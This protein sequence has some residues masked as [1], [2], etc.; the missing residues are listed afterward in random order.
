MILKIFHA[1]FKKGKVIKT[2]LFFVTI[3]D[4]LEGFLKFNFLLGE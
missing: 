2:L 1:I 4:N 3:K